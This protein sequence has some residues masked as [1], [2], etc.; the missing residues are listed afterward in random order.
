MAWGGIFR[1]WGGRGQRPD[2][3]RCMTSRMPCRVGGMGFAYWAGLKLEHLFGSR[4]S[5]ISTC[6][7]LEQYQLAAAQSLGRKGIWKTGWMRLLRISAVVPPD[8]SFS[9]KDSKATSNP[10]TRRKIIGC[11]TRLDS[12]VLESDHHLPKGLPLTGKL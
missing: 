5:S 11:Q 6:R 8:W 12:W 2:Q 10:F 3:P 1:V 9:S 4:P 7:G